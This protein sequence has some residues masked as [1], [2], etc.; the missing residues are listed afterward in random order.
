MDKL[1]VAQ[2]CRVSTKTKE[3]TQSI[4]RQEQ[5]N[6]Y[7]IMNMVHLGKWE[8][9]GAYIDQSSGTT[10]KYRDSYNEMMRDMAAKKFDAIVMKS[11]DRGWRN[12]RD[13]TDFEAAIRTHKIQLIFRGKSAYNPKDGDEKLLTG[14]EALLAERFSANQSAKSKS[15]AAWKKREGLVSSNGKNWGYLYKNNKLTVNDDEAAMIRLIDEMC[16]AG[17]G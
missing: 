9:V 3:Q 16:A 4:D 13:W 5:D 1:R 15:A 11:M 8:Y 10:T 12:L 14:F 6:E 2:Y 7:F 17:V